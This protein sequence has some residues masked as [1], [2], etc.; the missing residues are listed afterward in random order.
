MAA[1]IKKQNYRLPPE[2]E[3]KRMELYNRGFTDVEIAKALGHKQSTITSWRNSRNLETNKKRRKKYGP[4]LV[5]ECEGCKFANKEKNI[6][7]ALT[8]PGWF[9]R[10][11]KKCSFRKEE[12]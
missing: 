11:G 10:N 8:E 12:R 1:V 9:W 6:C 4:K 7:D 2:E 5:P 3:A